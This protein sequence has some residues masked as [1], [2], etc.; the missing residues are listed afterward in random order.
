MPAARPQPLAQIQSFGAGEEEEEEAGVGGRPAACDWRDEG[1]GAHAGNGRGTNGH[2]NGR[3]LPSRC[4]IS[5]LSFYRGE[6]RV[7]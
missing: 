7:S 4:P 2:G 5:Q 3:A 1:G 6:M